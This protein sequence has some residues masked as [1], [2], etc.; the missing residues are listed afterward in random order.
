[1]PTERSPADFDGEDPREILTLVGMALY[2]AQIFEVALTNLAV[3]LYA[4]RQSGLI[5]A[6]VVA[7]FDRL[8]AETLGVI[9]KEVRK[10]ISLDIETEGRFRR[11]LDTRNHLAHRFFGVHDANFTNVNGRKLM[12]AELHKMTQDLWQ[13]HHAVEEMYLPLWEAVGI[14]EEQMA[15][16]VEQAK[17]EAVERWRDSVNCTAAVVTPEHM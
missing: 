3:G 4:S 16:S 17:R 14:T 13:G 1:L 2:Q 8:G 9:L 10:Y 5:R 11:L 7:L 15:A 6:D 12:A